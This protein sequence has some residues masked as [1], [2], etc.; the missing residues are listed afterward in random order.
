M[1]AL[2]K[3]RD[4]LGRITLDLPRSP[5]RLRKLLSGLQPLDFWDDLLTDPARSSR[6]DRLP[7]AEAG[8]RGE[9]QR[10]GDHDG[11]PPPRGLRRPGQRG[12]RRG[13]IRAK[14]GG[15]G[16]AC[17][18][19]FGQTPI[20][21]G[22]NR[23]RHVGPQRPDWW[24]LV[25][26]DRRNDPEVRVAGERPSACQHL[27]E[28]SAQRKNVGPRVNRPAFGLLRR[29]VRRR[30]HDQARTRG[31]CRHRVLIWRAF[32]ELGQP[33][34]EHLGASVRGDDDVGR[35]DVAM[36]DAARVRGLERRRDLRAEIEGL[37]H[38]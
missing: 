14:R 30:P 3:P 5:N 15:T 36:D 27:V 37:G 34:V 16:V 32:E 29:H 38:R 13:E 17:R 18:R 19:I 31:V 35:L 23:R 10:H 8:R 26:Q 25:A 33:E 24:R 11:R 4:L 21:D 7:D 6:L 1:P 2:P 22:L 20:D 28:H 9:Q 12:V